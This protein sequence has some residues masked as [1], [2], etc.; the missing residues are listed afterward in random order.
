[1]KARK[2]EQA[3]P[4]YE[5]IE[6]YSHLWGH[7]PK[8]GKKEPV[9]G[10]CWKLTT[11]GP[12]FNR[13]TARVFADTYN[14]LLEIPS[15][16]QQLQELRQGMLGK[17]GSDLDWSIKLLCDEFEIKGG[18][19]W[20]KWLIRAWNPST[21]SKPPFNSGLRPRN[22]YPWTIELQSQG[23]DLTDSKIAR[24]AILTLNAGVSSREAQRAAAH[25]VDLLS[26]SRAIKRGR[27]GL[28]EIERLALYA[29]FEKYG[30]PK[31]Q[32]R[33]AII[34]RVAQTMKKQNRPMS[35]TAI[36]NE[37]RTWLKEKGHPVKQY[38]TE[39]REI[40]A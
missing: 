17:P 3:K 38:V 37:Y 8:E 5:V 10:Q 23:E 11:F 34:R 26:S 40:Q 20:I 25:A 32:R 6:G 30:T 15:F 13:K 24:R 7:V 39:N 29:E 36:G 2:S 31:R 12:I 1:M 19:E 28:T 18:E 16:R 35:Q 27:P 22:F 14:A 9:R 4:E 21:S 33:L